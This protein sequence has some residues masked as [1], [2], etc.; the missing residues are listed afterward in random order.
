MLDYEFFYIISV[1]IYI[2]ILFF[3]LYKKFHIR[4]IILISA[5]YFYGVSLFAITIFPIP[6]QGLQEIWIYYQS[7]NNFLPF[8]SLGNIL[9][10]DHL[11]FFVKAKQVAWNIIIFIPLW[12]FLP[13]FIKKKISF[14]QILCIGFLCSL[15]IETLQYLISL[16][17][18][19]NYK[20]T[21]VDDVILNTLGGIIWFYLYKYA[22]FK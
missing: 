12:F 17:L 18:G 7:N 21:D 15:W 20:I 6:I 22:D 4:K 10:N 9:W 5:F 11:S 1:P 14:T 2:F 3:L 16:F 8:L 13:F 19:F